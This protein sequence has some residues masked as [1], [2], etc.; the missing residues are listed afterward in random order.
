[1]LPCS[2]E[3]R[4]M[5]KLTGM[6]GP[7]VTSFEVVDCRFARSEGRAYESDESVR[8]VAV[9]VNFMVTD[10]GAS[11]ASNLDHERYGKN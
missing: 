2:V 10:N 9:I 11:T 7:C 4:A 3:P 1:M 6:H 8:S 5:M